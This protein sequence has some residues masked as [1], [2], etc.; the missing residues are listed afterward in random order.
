MKYKPIPKKREKEFY[1]LLD[2]AF[3][4]HKEEKSYENEE[5]YWPIVGGEFRGLFDRDDILSVSSIIPF[6]TVSRGKETKMGGITTVATPPEYRSRGFV[7]AML[8]KLLGELRDRRI[9]LSVLWPFSYPF[10]NKLGWSRSQDVINYSMDPSILKREDPGNSGGLFRVNSGEYDLI[11]PAYLKYVKKFNLPL[12]RW[13][14]W[15]DEH[16]MNHWKINNYCYG[17]KD[18]GRVRSYVLYHIEEG[19]GEEWKRKMIVDEMVFEGRTSFSQLLSFLYSH[20]SQA[21]EILIRAPFSEEMP[22]HHVFDDPREVEVTVKP[23]IMTRIVDVKMALESLSPPEEL[24][25]K[26]RI[27]LRDPV[28]DFNQGTFDLEVGGGE[29]V[30][31]RTD[32]DNPRPDVELD[33]NTLSQVYSGHL[34]IKQAR[35]LNL[36]VNDEDKA[37]ILEDV[38]PPARVFFNEGF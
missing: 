24:N 10:Y 34:S 13:N 3:R 18:E 9:Y 7:R 26:L 15:W 1:K 2:Y 17:W 32:D 8:K 12:K 22:F 38:F 14:D 37:E 23:G 20:S 35:F 4:P 5:D 21:H 27:L 28:L 36:K 6:S 31:T 29:I 11:E 30:Y 33:V 25:G 16:I 19:S